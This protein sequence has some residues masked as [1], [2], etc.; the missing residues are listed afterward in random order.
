ME[1]VSLLLQDKD[2]EL[3]C[4]EDLGQSSLLWWCLF[5]TATMTL[6]TANVQHSQTMSSYHKCVELIHRSC[7]QQTWINSTEHPRLTQKAP[8]FHRWPFR[9]RY[10]RP[11]KNP[12][13]TL[14]RNK[15]TKM[16]CCCWGE[17]GQHG[18]KAV[19]TPTP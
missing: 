3:G 13:K 14:D 17:A 10:K 9:V 4:G 12:P 19:E 2:T 11:A 6:P 1:E 5:C 15:P 18:G 7:H 8:F 16:S